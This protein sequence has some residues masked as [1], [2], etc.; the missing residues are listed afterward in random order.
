MKYIYPELSPTDFGLFRL[1]GAGL[2]NNLFVAARA[3][4]LSK[5]YGQKMLRPTWER[6]GVGQ[7]MRGERDKRVYAGLFRKESLFKSLH[8]LYVIKT[9]RFYDEFSAACDKDV[10]VSGLGRYYE[11]IISGYTDVR[12]WFY[13]AINPNAVS[14][15]PHTLG[16]CIA[17]HVR[18]GDY[19]PELRINLGWYIDVVKLI[20]EHLRCATRFLLFSDGSDE[21]LGDLLSLDEVSRV[22]Y[23]NALADM[24]AISRC[25]ALIGSDSTFSGW[26]AYLGQIPFVAK[27]FYPGNML[28]KQED[29]YIVNDPANL[30]ETFLEKIL[31]C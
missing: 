3:F 19:P 23:G 31:S 9:A 28:I 11:D 1:G 14:K 12:K 4:L 26:G 24:V 15:V 22:S 27:H 29:Y 2:A 16:D 20:S 13:E 21:E 5:K 6:I 18:L 30:P 7:L 10:K 8:K 17:I 25:K